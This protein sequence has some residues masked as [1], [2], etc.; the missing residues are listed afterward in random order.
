MKKKSRECLCVDLRKWNAGCQDVFEAGAGLILREIAREAAH[1]GSTCAFGHVAISAAA[2]TVLV[3]R[4]STEGLFGNLSQNGVLVTE[5]Y[6][7][8]HPHA[9]HGGL[10]L[11]RLLRLNDGG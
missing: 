10:G 5:L 9:G 7:H 2:S 11:R 6:F 3:K 1:S 4:S 8:V